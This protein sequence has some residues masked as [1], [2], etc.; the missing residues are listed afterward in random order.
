MNL[1]IKFEIAEA[2][3][4]EDMNSA[5]VNAQPSFPPITAAN[6]Q[7]AV[8]Y[9]DTQ[10]ASRIDTLDKLDLSLLTHVLPDLDKTQMILHITAQYTGRGGG[11]SG[12][13]SGYDRR[14]REYS[15]RGG[16]YV[17]DISRD[18]NS[19]SNVRGGNVGNNAR[20]N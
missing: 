12:Q 17:R 4:S 9:G 14:G 13:V 15:G 1:L 7:T 2:V 16:G 20:I 19:D 10:F 8:V 5:M 6:G 11:Y 18:G 3:C